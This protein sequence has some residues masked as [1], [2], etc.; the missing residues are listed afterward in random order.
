MPI[1]FTLKK[2][3]IVLLIS[4]GLVFAAL[5]GWFFILGKTSQSGQPPGLVDG[6]LARCP[7]KRNCVC[8]EYS[9]DTIHYIEPVSVDDSA[10]ESAMA[11]AKT[12]VQDMGGV[13]QHHKDNYLAA[14]FS[15]DL[16]GFVDDL[17]LRFV[18]EEKL[19]QIRSGSRVG[20]GDLG[21][22]RK[23]AEQFR[24]RLLELT[25]K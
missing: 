16:F 4:C 8:S 17:E 24:D 5:M 15:S 2:V 19:I 14:T 18:P 25:V 9:T 13:I 22:N 1:N 20:E 10:V 11:T 12:T 6:K 23:R 3:M 21:V 7:D